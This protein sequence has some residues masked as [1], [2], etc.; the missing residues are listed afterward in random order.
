M[1]SHN[2]INII[3][4]HLYK[5]VPLNQTSNTEHCPSLYPHRLSSRKRR[6]RVDCCEVNPPPGGP[7]PNA[8]LDLGGVHFRY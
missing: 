5:S 2:M 3:A 4:M 6:F 8:R 7:V 1:P